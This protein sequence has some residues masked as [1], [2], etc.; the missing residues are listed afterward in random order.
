MNH[1][2]FSRYIQNLRLN[3]SLLNPNIK[4]FVTSH[5]AIFLSQQEYGSSSIHPYTFIHIPDQSGMY[6]CEIYFSFLIN[7]LY[8]LTFKVLL[9]CSRQKILY[10]YFR[11]VE[12]AV[13]LVGNK[14]D[15]CHVR[16]VCWE[17]G[18]KL[19]VDN[20]CQFCELSAAEQF[21]EVE[22]MFLGI[23]KDILATFKVKEKRRPSGSKSMAKLI[24]NVFGKRRK[25]V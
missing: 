16:E 24:N 25:S 14:Q 17:E 10:L 4:N 6:A 21:L 1:A 18:H 13:L 7:F 8:K 23:I 22:M 20:R 2:I 9:T 19:A 3:L 5:L 12:S 15:L 11:P